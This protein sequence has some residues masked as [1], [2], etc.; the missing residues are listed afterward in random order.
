MAWRAA[1][2]LPAAIMGVA[3]GAMLVSASTSIDQVGSDIDGEAAYDE[4]GW[5]VSLSSD[6]T[7]VAIGPI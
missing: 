2:A 4:S 6:G 5:S 1:L 3:G 7:V